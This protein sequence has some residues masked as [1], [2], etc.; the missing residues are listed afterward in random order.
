MVEIK[1]YKKVDNRVRIEAEKEETVLKQ[2]PFMFY[3]FIKSRLPFRITKS[4]HDNAHYEH[5]VT[6]GNSA[7]TCG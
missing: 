5:A 3:I 7:V 6:K 4:H 2:S 1:Y